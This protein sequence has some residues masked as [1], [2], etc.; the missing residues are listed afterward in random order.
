MSHSGTALINPDIIFRKIVLS[1]GQRV[2]D[3]GC[4][5]TGHLVFPAA[6]VVGD[7]GIVYAV[8]ILKSVLQSLESRVKSEGFSNVATVWSDIE[9]LG[10]TPIPASTID[11]CF[12]V[13][14]LSGLN[15]PPEVLAEAKRLL[16]TDGVLVVVEWSKRLGPLGPH[17]HDLISAAT[18]NDW[19]KTAGLKIE[20][21]IDSVGEYHFAQ[22]LRKI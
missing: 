1:A 15:R 19:A 8:D 11:A 14:V 18:I 7:T 4:G 16:K 5:R 10:K 12:L 20:D 17:G 13:G 9:C 2:A 22:I 6:R 3:L 21:I